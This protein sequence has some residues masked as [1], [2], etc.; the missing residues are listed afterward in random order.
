MHTS[1]H[2]PSTAFRMV[3]GC[4]CNI[5][6][7]IVHDSACIM[8]LS[9]NADLELGLALSI[10]RDLPAAPMGTPR[11]ALMAVLVKAHPH[12][13]ESQTPTRALAAAAMRIR[14]RMGNHAPGHGAQ[15]AACAVLCLRG[16]GLQ[17]FSCG[18]SPRGLTST[19]T[20]VRMRA[21]WLVAGW[22]NAVACRVRAGALLP[23]PLPQ[24]KRTAI[25]SWLQG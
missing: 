3:I 8:L 1:D 22:Q 16:P 10:Y 2:R 20:A 7:G 13:P 4:C 12:A 11:L 21:A 9:G 25:L 18:G 19:G 17:A 23:W 6:N 15:P 5:D 24:H 14:I